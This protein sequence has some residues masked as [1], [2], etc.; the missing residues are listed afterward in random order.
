MSGNGELLNIHR[1]STHFPTENGG[2]RVVEAVDLEIGRGEIVGLVG[3]SGCGKTVTALSIMRLIPSPGR[4]VDGEI[5][6]EK[7]NLIEK[8]EPEMRK[9]RGNRISM[10]FQEPMSSL[11]PVLTIGEQIAEAIKSHQ[12]LSKAQ[13]NSKA[14]EMLELVGVPAPATRVN[15]YP[16]Q[17]SGGMR[18]RVMIAMALA[19]KPALLIADEPTTALDVTI[20][21]QILGL[22]KSLTR[23]MGASLLLITHDFGVIAEVCDQVAVMYA[24]SIVERASTKALFGNPRHPYIR[25]LLNSVP[26]I[27]LDIERLETIEGTVP[28]PARLPAG[29]RFHPRCSTA[30]EICRQQKPRTVEVESGHWVRCWLAGRQGEL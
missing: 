20:Q 18:Q 14:V 11:N 9:I 8:S 2:V 15:E 19:C 25:G 24:G 5:W 26:R 6:F 1:L 27:D 28:N 30:E 3:E 17:L 10:I 23:D 4:M 21:A 22:M 16:H 12:G 13:A 29:C 7:E